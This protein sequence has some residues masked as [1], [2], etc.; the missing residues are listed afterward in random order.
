M[1]DQTEPMASRALHR[2][3]PKA[4]MET[5]QQANSHQ[6]SQP[7]YRCMASNSLSLQLH[8]AEFSL[9]KL[10]KSLQNITQFM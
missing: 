4:K 9:Y 2:K 6:L 10:L 5:A 8:T 3:P 7:Q 1:L